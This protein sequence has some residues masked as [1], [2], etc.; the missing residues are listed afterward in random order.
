MSKLLH[1]LSLTI[2]S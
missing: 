2:H 1:Y